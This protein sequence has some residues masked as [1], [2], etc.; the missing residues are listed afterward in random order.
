MHTKEKSITTLQKIS[1]IEIKLKDSSYFIRIHK[2]FIISIKHIEK[3][4]SDFIYLKNGTQL[5]IGVSYR[6]HINEYLNLI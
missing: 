3:L 4:K 2:S 1:D 5:S 6:V